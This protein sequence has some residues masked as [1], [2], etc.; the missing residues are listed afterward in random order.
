VVASGYNLQNFGDSEMQNAGISKIYKKTRSNTWIREFFDGCKSM[1]NVGSLIYNFEGFEVKGDFHYEFEIADETGLAQHMCGS[2]ENLTYS[3]GYGCCNHLL[4]EIRVNCHIELDG[5]EITIPIVSKNR[6]LRG[7]RVSIWNTI[8]INWDS[9]KYNT[10]C[11]M[12][13][14]RLDAM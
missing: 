14:V 8:F 6:N 3:Y 4:G 12:K 1:K 5:I 7:D 11:N 13:L 10:R 9:K 2:I